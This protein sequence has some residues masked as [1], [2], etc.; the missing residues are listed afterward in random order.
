MGC[1]AVELIDSRSLQSSST[2]FC[3]I[4]PPHTLV[5]T[6]CLCHNSRCQDDSKEDAYKCNNKYNTRHG[7]TVLLCFSSQ[8]GRHHLVALLT[9]NVRSLLGSEYVCESLYKCLWFVCIANRCR[10]RRGRGVDM[11]VRSKLNI[12]IFLWNGS[13]L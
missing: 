10:D 4:E 1:R 13:V 7:A 8:S 11:I 3:E 6:A 2:T 9:V 5:M 12:V